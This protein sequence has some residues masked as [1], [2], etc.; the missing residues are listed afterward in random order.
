MKVTTTRK[1]RAEAII[2][3]ELK[4]LAAQ[5]NISMGDMLQLLIKKYKEANNEQRNS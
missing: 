3:Q 2:F 4:I 1:L 5:N